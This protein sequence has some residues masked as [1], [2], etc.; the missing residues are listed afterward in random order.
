[1]TTQRG[2]EETAW[3]GHFHNT[4]KPRELR[5]G[6]PTHPEYYNCNPIGSSASGRKLKGYSEAVQC[7]TVHAMAHEGIYGA[8]AW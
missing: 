5:G 3:A 2:L 4:G 1:M 8:C 7:Y 6:E